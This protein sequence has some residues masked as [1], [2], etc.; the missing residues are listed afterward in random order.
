[1]EEAKPHLR[2]DGPAAHFPHPPITKVEFTPQRG[3]T[4]AVSATARPVYQY[5]R[6]HMALVCLL[7]FVFLMGVGNLAILAWLHRPT[8]VTLPEIG[9]RTNEASPF[10]LA[11]IDGLRETSAWASDDPPMPWLQQFSKQGAWGVSITGEPTLTAPCVRCILSGRRPDLI[12]GFQ[13]FDAPKAPG[14]VIEYLV[15]RGAQAAHGG[16][17]AVYQMCR[18]YYKPEAAYQVPDRGPVDQGETDRIAVPFV[19]ARIAEGYDLISLHLTSPDHAGHKHGATGRRYWEACRFVDEMLKAS[20]EAFRAMHPRATVCIASDHGMSDMGTHGGGEAVARRAP[21]C[22]VGPGILPRGPVETNQSSIAPTLCAALGLPQP[23]LADA[24]PEVDWIRESPTERRAILRDYLEAR[25]QVARDVSGL[26]VDFI[27]RRRALRSV[28][29][30]DSIDRLR[31]ESLIAELEAMVNPRHEVPSVMALL[32]ALIGFIWL[33]HVQRMNRLVHGTRWMCAVAAVAAAFL[34]GVLPGLSPASVWLASGVTILVIG[35]AAYLARRNEQF[36][37]VAVACA[38]V[39]FAIPA[40][41]AAGHTFQSTWER[42]T[43]RSPETSHLVFAGIVGLVAA[44]ILLRPLCRRR[45]KGPQKPRGHASP[46]LLAAFGGAA[47]GGLLSLR[48]FVQ[49]ILTTKELI[50]IAASVMLL[51]WLRR[52][53]ASRARQAFV[54]GASMFVIWVPRIAE[55]ILDDHW[56]GA[57]AAHD[58][59]WFAAGLAVSV[60]VLWVARSGDRSRALAL[61]AVACVLLPF[62]FRLTNDVDRQRWFGESG[63]I[64]VALA[65]T[66]LPLVLLVLSL[67][68][69]SPDF[70]WWLQLAAAIALARRLS[71]KDAEFLVYACAGC[72]GHAATALRLPTARW[73]I[74]WLAIL[75]IVFR[76]AL[77]HAM[78]FIESFST[79]DVGQAFEGLGTARNTVP[80]RVG[81]VTWQIGVATVQMAIRMALPWVLLCA[82]LMRMAAN[83]GK[84]GVNTVRTAIADV[85]VGLAGRGAWIVWALW[86]WWRNAWWTGYAQTVYAYAGAD[87]LLVVGSAL[88]VGVLQH[89]DYS[90]SASTSNPLPA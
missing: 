83:S 46:V 43:V 68:V 90:S 40:L 65:T 19:L 88:L 32:L 22:L 52:S 58:V 9:A 38:A 10:F 71:V 5:R 86:V 51:L 89:D 25:A 20:I 48:P 63:A 84:Y 66:A 76:T 80:D 78:G 87:I 16:D 37:R 56:I 61:L 55:R 82:V 72:I 77:F 85:S 39:L 54:F 45:A 57:V 69:S 24:P 23:P 3:S 15:K 35:V 67:R 4:I 44:F 59:G 42:F 21:F 74:A 27:E 41:A 73:R 64:V 79:L 31:I 8:P 33:V 13:N 36:A 26:H 1:M 2:L 7:S 28:Q 49:P 53:M 18:D 47:V 30:G 6:G 12:T 81:G 62:L 14:S 50:A 60:I 75:L 29:D 11:V 17:A 70:R 34:L